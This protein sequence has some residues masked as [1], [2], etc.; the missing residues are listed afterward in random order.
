MRLLNAPSRAHLTYPSKM[1]AKL[2]SSIAVALALVVAATATP[3]FNSIFERDPGARET[4]VRRAAPI[5]LQSARRLNLTSLNLLQHDQ[6]RAR[7]LE[8]IGQGNAGSRI[9][10]AL[11]P[12]SIPATNAAVDYTVSVSNFDLPAFV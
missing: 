6:A 4:I 7:Q 2:T 1:L 11:A 5:T 8:A 3:V 9:T 12:G 10:P